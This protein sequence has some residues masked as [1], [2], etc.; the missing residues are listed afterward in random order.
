[1]FVNNQYLLGRSCDQ[2]R[3][4]LL[5]AL[6]YTLLVIVSP[7]TLMAIL[8]PAESAAA[9]N[10]FLPS[11]RVSLSAVWLV[12]RSNSHCAR[13]LPMMWGRA[14]VT[15]ARATATTLGMLVEVR[16]SER[17]MVW[18]GGGGFSCPRVHSI[19]YQGGAWL[20]PRP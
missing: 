17:F 11:L 16:R 4:L 5:L 13:C 1:M 19:G 9:C 10:A 18:V 15:L 8:R 12:A 7:L 20:W 2:L 3:N 6:E 14:T